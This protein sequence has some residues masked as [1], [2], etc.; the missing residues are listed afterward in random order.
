MVIKQSDTLS[1]IAAPIIATDPALQQRIRRIINALLNDV[2]YI[3]RNG[4]PRDRL[5]LFNTIIPQLMKSASQIDASAADKAQQ[6]AFDR[7]MGQLRGE[8]E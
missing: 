2:E 5:A 4:T 3:I 8:S 1:N 7:L 6:E